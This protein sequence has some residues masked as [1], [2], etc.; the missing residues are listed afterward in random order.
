MGCKGSCIHTPIFYIYRIVSKAWAGVCMEYDL[1]IL[2]LCC[3]YQFF[4]VLYCSHLSIGVSYAYKYS[5]WSYGLCKLVW[6]YN[7]ISI[8]LEV[9]YFP[10]LSFQ[11]FK[12]VKYGMMFYIGGNYMPSP[13]LISFQYA[14]NGKVVG[15]YATR[16]K[17]Y[18]LWRVGVYKG[19]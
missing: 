3:L 6:M 9:C 1:W 11:T 12:W 15:L 4:D 18:L 2:L 14:L 13:F 5:V 7:T 16:C 10:T 17:Y 19:S 8:R